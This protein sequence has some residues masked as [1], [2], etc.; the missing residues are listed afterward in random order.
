MNKILIVEKCFEMCKMWKCYFE[1]VFEVVIAK[2]IDEA[3]QMLKKHQN[4]VVI[5]LG[6][7]PITNVSALGFVKSFKGLVVAMSPHRQI[8]EQLALFYGCKRCNPWELVTM[9]DKRC[10][11]CS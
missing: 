4:V 3:S 6:D 5:A 8:N 1:G 7:V 11:K 9:L 10:L 2:S